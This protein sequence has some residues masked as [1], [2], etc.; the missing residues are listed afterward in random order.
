M[1]FKT[2]SFVSAAVLLALFLSACSGSLAL[3]EGAIPDPVSTV[4]LGSGGG[5]VYQVAIGELSRMATAAVEVTVLDVQRSSTNAAD[6]GFPR[7]DTSKGPEQLVGLQIS[8]DIDVRIET[9]YGDRDDLDGVLKPGDVVTITVGGG[10]VFATFTAEEA[11]ALGVLVA[12]GEP[13]GGDE[14]PPGSDESS[15][16]PPQTGVES[17]P[18]QPTGISYGVAPAVRLTEGETVILFL[19]NYDR[20]VYPVTGDSIQVLDVAHPYGV[21]RKTAEGGW[22][23]D[24]QTA[25]AVDVLSIAAD[26]ENR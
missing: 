17:Y 21:F 4:N 14:P 12:V 20:P 7:I 3:D 16:S 18:T 9:V 2:R 19:T 23:S 13:A 5:S 6:R 25:P 11:R 10:E 8:T 24:Y 1:A 22:Q 15:A 26:V